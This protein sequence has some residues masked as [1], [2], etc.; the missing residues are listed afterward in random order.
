[1][2]REFPWIENGKQETAFVVPEND[3]IVGVDLE[4]KSE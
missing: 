4:S 2:Y 1:M 3:L